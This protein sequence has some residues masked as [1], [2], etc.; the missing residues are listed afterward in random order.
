MSGFSDEELERYARHLVL[1]EIGGPGQQKLKRARMLMI[2]AGG[3]GAPALQYLAAA[4]VGTLG[5]VDDDRVG[6]SNLQRQVIHSTARIGAAKVDSAAAAIHDINPHVTV[7]TH[8]VRLDAQNA[9]ETVSGYDLVIDGSDNFATRYLVSDACF[10]AGRPLVT[11]AVGRF[12]GSVTTLA[13]H[14][15]DA[16]GAPNPTYRCLFPAPP[17]AGVVPSC[18][19]AGIL[20]VVPGIVGTIQ[21]L[22]AI[23][24][25]TGTGEPLIGRLL[26]FDAMTTRFE[27][28]SYRRDPANPLNG[29]RARYSDL[30][31][32]AA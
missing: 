13:P 16:D 21:A 29:D 4:G 18:A 1:P 15:D 12:D 32:H 30:S 24:L 22:E 3:L 9:I 2:G 31:H 11:A 10:F 6:L 14:L 19:E 28:F 5:I 17:E 23:K 26:L 20:G 27:T 8:D 7:E 25:A